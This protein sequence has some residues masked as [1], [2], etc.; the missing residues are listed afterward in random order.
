M[1][2]DYYI[3]PEDYERAA[4]QGVSRMRLEYR[5]RSWAWEKE[6]AISTPPRPLQDRS[7][8]R[9]VAEA[10]GIPRA[11]F[12]NRILHHGWGEERAAT[13]P[14]ATD[15][16]RAANAR[17]GME[18]N[19]VHPPEYIAL[20]RAN[21]IPYK[22]FTWRV[23]HGWGYERAATEAKV[24]PEEAGRRAKQR[25]TELYGDINAPIFK[26]STSK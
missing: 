13:Q 26:S 2:Y 7:E 21:G 15:V 1:G 17:I 23:R 3:T 9:K 16:D 19:R 14:I 4:T 8:W 6:R 25:T 11:L 22:R 5:I 20:A 10:N 24:P 12:Y 18:A